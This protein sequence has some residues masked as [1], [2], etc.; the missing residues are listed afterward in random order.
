MMKERTRI[1]ALSLMIAAAT[2]TVATAAN[3]TPVRSLPNLIDVTV[4]EQTGATFAHVFNPAGPE[5]TTRLG[6]PLAAGNNDFSTTANEFYDVFYSNADGSF[7]IDGAFITAQARFHAT[8]DANGGGLNINEIQLNFSGGV[9]EFGDVVT[10]F[11]SHG[12]GAIPASA[13]LAADGDLTTWTTLGSTS[14]TDPTDRLSVTVGFAST[15]QVPEPSSLIPIVIGLAA[16]GVVRRLR[17]R[18][19]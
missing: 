8:S 19:Q 13:P 7:N 11:V 10:S 16:A 2:L 15:T 12:F 4:F 9:N 1:P 17:I 14:D 18:S 5:L 6:D 3:A